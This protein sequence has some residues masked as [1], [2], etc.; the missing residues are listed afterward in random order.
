[1]TLLAFIVA[2]GLLITVH[3]WGHYRMAVA[4]GVQVM[5]FSV[6]FG[7]PLMRWKRLQRNT[8]CETEFVLGLVP[9]GGY[10][11]MLDGREGVLPPEARAR[12]FDSQSLWARAA[13]V[14]A[15]PVANLLLA[16]LLYA[17]TFWIGQ[18]ETRA[19][20]AS[21]VAG[22]PAANAGVRSGD[23][24]LRAGAAES[25]LQEV[26]SLEDLGWQILQHASNAPLYLEL[27]AHGHGVKRVVMLRPPSDTGES[28][29]TSGLPSWGLGQ[30]W[31]AA[32]IGEVVR[33]QVADVAGLRRGDEV[34]RI[35]GQL[36]ADAAELRATVRASG[37][38][39]EPIE[40]VWQIQRNGAGF[41]EITVKPEWVH[42]QQSSFGRIG[43]QVGQPPERVWVQ[44]AADDGLVKALQRTRD[45]VELNVRM[46]GRM[47]TGQA[48]LANLNGP[49]TMAEFA[50]RTASLGLS[51]YLGYLAM[52][53]VSLGIF[54]LLP[55]PVLDGGHL[56]YYLFE[57]VTGRPL[58]PQWVEVLQR[59]GM[60]VLLALMVFALFNDLVRLG[61]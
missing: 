38:S 50:G 14:A 28:T 56:M 49:L 52:L 55:L 44:Y 2:L 25:D 39:H 12:A 21:P 57:A 43:V 37:Q 42:E 4:F 47:L 9:L 51:A 19:V 40:Q 34:L 11:K 8:G 7:Q 5:R 17:A 45:M 54:N 53:S 30:V 24:V 41:M 20:M 10:V 1:M 46:I 32:V 26:A 48:S 3:E 16:V 29:T 61:W 23:W 58:A 59:I 15:G 18:F 13:I 60:M 36:V 6:G 31:S 22:S 35:D 33:G 27:Q